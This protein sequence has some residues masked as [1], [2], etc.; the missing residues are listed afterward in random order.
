MIKFGYAI[1]YVSDVLK[2]IEFYEKAFGFS[3]K[4]IAPGNEY[5]ELMTGEATLGFAA[6]THAK[7]NLPKGFIESSMEQLPFGIEIGFVTDDVDAVLKNAKQYSGIIVAE[8]QQKPWG[9]TVCY[10][11]DPDGF[12]VEVCTAMT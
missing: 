11:R 2:S 3:R 12:L 1:L 10:L 6:K 7:K 5:G 9:Q 8:P 4:F